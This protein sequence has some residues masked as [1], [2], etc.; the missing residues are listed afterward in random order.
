MLII[1][2]AQQICVA[3]DMGNTTNVRGSELP[4]SDS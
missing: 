3:T 1:F 2:K 4:T